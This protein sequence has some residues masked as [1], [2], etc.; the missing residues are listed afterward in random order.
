MFIRVSNG[1]KYSRMD[2]VK[3]VE[4]SLYTDHYPSNVLKAVFYKFY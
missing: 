3:F 1:T 2:Q 4:D